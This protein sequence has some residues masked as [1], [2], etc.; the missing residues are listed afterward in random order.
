VTYD[1]Q[2]E[3]LTNDPEV[4]DRYESLLGLMIPTIGL[5]IAPMGLF[6][7]YFGV[8]AS[9]IL[10]LTLSAVETACSLSTNLHVQVFRFVLFSIWYPFTFATW[11]TFQA[12]KFGYTHFG[13][14]YAIIAVTSGSVNFTNDALTFRVTTDGRSA[15]AWINVILIAC[16]GVFL[17]FGIFLWVWD[18]YKRHKKSMQHTK[19]LV[20]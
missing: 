3:W 6:P 4:I 7:D 12:H 20:H 17:I 9:A 18:S 2:I 14:L 15:M 8:Y 11:V 10:L 19:P 1:Q 5:L 13:G 16:C